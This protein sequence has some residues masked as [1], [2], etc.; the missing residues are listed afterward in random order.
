MNSFQIEI[1]K[2]LKTQHP[3][4]YSSVTTLLRRKNADAIDVD[5]VIQTLLK[6]G[7]ISTSNKIDYHNSFLSLTPKGRTELFSSYDYFDAEKKITRRYWVTTG[8][9]FTALIKA[10]W[11]QIVMVLTLMSG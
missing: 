9:A 6:E 7:Y 4:R 1:L 2:Y 11:P 10:F 3:A 8:I 5:A